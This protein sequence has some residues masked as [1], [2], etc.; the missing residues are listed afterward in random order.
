MDDATHSA[1]SFTAAVLLPVWFTFL[2]FYAT[3]GSAEGPSE[4]TPIIICV[5]A[6]LAIPYGFVCG[7]V[8]CPTLA[9]ISGAN[10]GIHARVIASG[11]TI[12]STTALIASSTLGLQRLGLANAWQTAT[13]L[14]M[15]LFVPPFT[16][17]FVIY[18]FS[19][20]LGAQ[21]QDDG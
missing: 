12:A 14:G 5:I 20:R 17:C 13:Y 8:G 19:H 15:I 1:K 21:T 18:C 7:F 11:L 2:V 6:I 16:V 3:S 9:R 4:G 10:T